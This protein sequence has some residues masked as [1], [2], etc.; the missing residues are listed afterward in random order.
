MDIMKGDDGIGRLIFEAPLDICLILTFC[1][2]AKN[3][4]F[5]KNCSRNP[6][7]EDSGYY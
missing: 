3:G 4:S 1:G 5:G 6:K 2:T 7:F